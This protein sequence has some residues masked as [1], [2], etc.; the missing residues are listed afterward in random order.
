[1]TQVSAT[2][3]DSLAFDLSSSRT[4]SEASLLHTG[5][6]LPR[7]EQLA[8]WIYWNTMPPRFNL[9]LDVPRDEPEPAQLTIESFNV[10]Q[11]QDVSVLG[12]RDCERDPDFVHAA[13]PSFFR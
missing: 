9:A 13:S 10:R 12:V 2:H 8:T 7:C 11:S 5:T 3:A 6:D 4:D 1:M